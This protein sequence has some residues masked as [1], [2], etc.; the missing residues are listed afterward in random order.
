MLTRK[1]LV[2]QIAKLSLTYNKEIVSGQESIYE[3]A[4]SKYTDHILILAV[5]NAIT[6]EKFFPVPAVLV[7]YCKAVKDDLERNAP[8]QLEYIK[9]EEFVVNGKT[10]PELCRKILSDFEAGIITKDQF[11]FELIELERKLMNA[12][13]LPES[14]F[15]KC[16]KRIQEIGK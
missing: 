5:A 14:E 11:E 8:E 1:C 3:E 15:N 7:N 6:A 13:K 12:G 9:P 2:E 4:L 10:M 16:V